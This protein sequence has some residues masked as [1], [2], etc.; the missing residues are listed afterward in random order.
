MA[1]KRQRY[2][3][4]NIGNNHGRLV[5]RG[6]YQGEEYMVSL[7]LPYEKKWFKA[8]QKIVDAIETDIVYSSFDTS[9]ERYKA[10]TPK[11]LQIKPHKAKPLDLAQVWDRYQDYKSKQLEQ[12]TIEV[13]YT[14]AKNWIH[15]LPTKDI[16]K[17][18]AIRDYL[19]AQT[20]SKQAKAILK[21][22]SSACKWAVE[23]SLILENPFKS[24]A[25]SITLKKGEKNEIEYFTKQEMELIIAE[26]RASNYSGYYAQFVEFLFLTGCRPSE[27]VALRWED[28]SNDLSK[29][30]FSRA[31]VQ[32]N[33]V[34]IEKG[35]KTQEKRTF[36]CGQRLQYLLQRIKEESREGI[37]TV[38]HSPKGKPIN[39]LVFNREHWKGTARAIRSGG[40][41]V[42]R[43]ASERQI[44]R[45]L[46]QYST[47]H[48]FITLSLQSGIDVATV[49]S[50]VG[51]S[52]EVI[53]QH[54]SGKNQ[55][56]KSL[57][58][59]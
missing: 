54:Y 29:I 56:L 57:D 49:A 3:L 4:P 34:Q 23:S 39:L 18:V 58:F 32:V 53:Y 48:T 50:W 27:A 38:F 6:T 1:E 11:G 5:V 17:A 44:D 31:I 33:G 52:P 7:G 14:T 45:Y 26:F 37:D 47:R 59:L 9:L 24:L 30:T 36:P 25:G 16:S 2:G 13:R 28:I 19:L 46:T 40:G 22:F 43:L 35:L 12:T 10:L 21:D 51:N 42:T 55:S 15:R 8:A 20:T 41:V